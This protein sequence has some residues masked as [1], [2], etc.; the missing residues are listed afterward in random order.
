MLSKDLSS[1]TITASDVSAKA[2]SYFAA[3]Y[4]NK[5]AQGVAISSATYTA[6]NGNLGNTIQ[7][8]ASGSI[9]T[10]FMKILALF[11]P[12]PHQFDSMSFSATSTTA[13]GNVKMRVALVLD[14]TGSMVDNNKIVALRNAVAGSGGLIDQLSGLA[15]NPG[16]V[17]ISVIP[18]AKVVIM[19]ISCSAI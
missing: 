9:N 15:Q 3:L 12:N 4:T 11:T 2:Q 17:Y 5:D 14:N 10:D 1:G 6:N 16:D 8:T 18:F 7:L 19:P 13:W